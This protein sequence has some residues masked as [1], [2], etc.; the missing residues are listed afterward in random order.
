MSF[1][2]QLRGFRCK[3]QDSR[4]KR[5]SHASCVFAKLVVVIDRQDSS[6]LKTLTWSGVQ[7]GSTIAIGSAVTINQSLAWLVTIDER[8]SRGRLAYG[9]RVCWDE[10]IGKNACIE[11][12]VDDRLIRTET[13]SMLMQMNRKCVLV[14]WK[15][16]DK[17]A[18]HEEQQFSGG[19][20]THCWHESE[21]QLTVFYGWSHHNCLLEF[22]FKCTIISEQY[23]ALS[24]R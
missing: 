24:N 3:S 10:I 21:N 11:E 8:S 17:R 13:V 15:T 12:W 19:V 20:A 7:V 22:N 14:N 23:Y 6:W 4:F 1:P 9:H 16:I 5:V 18:T 2:L